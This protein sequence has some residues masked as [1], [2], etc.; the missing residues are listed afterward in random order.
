VRV[1]QLPGHAIERVPERLVVLRPQ[2]DRPVARAHGLPVDPVQPR[3]VIALAD[4]VPHE[5]ERPLPRRPR[6]HRIRRRRHHLRRHPLRLPHL[7][8]DHVVGIE[9]LAAGENKWGQS[10]IN[11]GCRPDAPAGVS[12]F[13]ARLPRLY[14]PGYPAHV[15][16][17]GN[18]G[19]DVFRSEG[20]RIFMHRCL[21]EIA[22]KC[23]IAVHA[24]VFMTNHI[25]LVATGSRADSLA[26]LDPGPRAPLRRLFQ[27]P[28]PENR[29]PVGRQISIERDRSG[30]VL[31]GLPSLC[32][33][34][35]GARGDGCRPC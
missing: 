9:D 2:R 10:Q 29:D 8:P 6:H 20:D 16:V 17:R 1:A 30:S 33:A 12:H 14:V 5:I 13:M 22:P 25:H 18:D 35:S 4:G 34:E 7:P 23:G 26:R 31:A 11:E 32:G 3:V 28:P 15:R 19:G 21:A 27:L 24:Y